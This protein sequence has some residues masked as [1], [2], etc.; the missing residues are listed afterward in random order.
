MSHATIDPF[1]LITSGI[2]LWADTARVMQS[3]Y[4]STL[5]RAAENMPATLEWG[6]LEI[7]V[8]K[9]TSVDSEQQL[10][11]AFQTAANINV[12]AWAH[13]ANILSAMPNWTQKPMEA[14]SKAMTDMFDRL[15]RGKV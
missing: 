3:Q 8:L 11:D 13:T 4:V 5:A 1:K 12:N 2:A 10:R 7:P 9:R 6:T 15:H 14:S